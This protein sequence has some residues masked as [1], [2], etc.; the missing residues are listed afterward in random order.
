MSV[1]PQ[2]SEGSPDL[3]QYQEQPQHAGTRLVRLVH[4]YLQASQK[5]IMNTMKISN[6]KQKRQLVHSNVRRNNCHLTNDILSSIVQL[7]DIKS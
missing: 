4:P 5:H 6:L 3:A 2:M 7:N 1:I